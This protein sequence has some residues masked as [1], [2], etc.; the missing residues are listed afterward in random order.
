[1]AKE[2]NMDTEQVKKV[3]EAQDKLI[4]E[5]EKNIEQTVV[6]SQAVSI[7]EYEEVKKMW[8]QQ[9]EKGE[10]PATENIKTRSEWVDQDIVVITNTLNKLFSSD[11]TIKQQG[12]DEVGYILPIFL[13]NNLSGEQ[14]VTY[15][16]A[17]IEAAKTVQALID[18]EKEVTER[19]KAKVEEVDVM[20]PKAKEAAKTMELKEELKI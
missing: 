15:L 19:L 13:V 6:M 4:S 2:N 14:L 20:K 9:Y 18:R 5:P 1:V 17:K 10:I 3:I 8:T 16:K 11:L 12:L 7:D